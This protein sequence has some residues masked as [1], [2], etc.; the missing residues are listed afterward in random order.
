M[1]RHMEA[2]ACRNM[3]RH[4]I[5]GCPPD[6]PA[7]TTSPQR[8]AADR[9]HDRAAARGSRRSSHPAGKSRDN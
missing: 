6:A 3:P 9:S 7:M 5:G 4:A 8:A 1:A 2:P